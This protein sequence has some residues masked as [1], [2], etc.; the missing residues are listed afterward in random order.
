MTVEA[1][2]RLFGEP[3]IN[4]NFML[5]VGILGL[6]VNILVAFYMHKGADLKVDLCF[7]LGRRYNRRRGRYEI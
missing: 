3:V 5:I 1:I 2:I 6:A 4:A 7:G